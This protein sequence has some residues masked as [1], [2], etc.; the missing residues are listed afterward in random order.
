MKYA[1]LLRW[2]TLSINSGIFFAIMFP[3]FLEYNATGIEVFYLICPSFPPLLQLPFRIVSCI[4][5]SFC[6]LHGL[7]MALNG[8]LVCYRQR[9][10]IVEILRKT[11]T[12][13]QNWK[14]R[15]NVKPLASANNASHM[16]AV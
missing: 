8:A 12:L 11:G 15:V 9:D 4:L 2:I 10:S 6:A 13:K 5:I 16:A 1:A 14:K 3:F 7:K